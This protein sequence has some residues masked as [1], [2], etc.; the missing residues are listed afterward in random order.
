MKTAQETV[1]R[2][3]K[4]VQLDPVDSRAHLCLGWSHAF[5]QEHDQAGT[6]M[7]LARELNPYDPGTLMSAAGY[8]AFSG[9]IGKGLA[10]ARE[11]IA[12]SISPAV[13]HWTYYAMVLF[14]SGN[15]AAAIDA[16]DHTSDTVVTLQ[17]WRV[18]SL[19][20]LGRK[21]DAIEEGRRFTNR[22]RPRWLG[23]DAPTDVAIVRWL[24]H[25]HPIRWP[26]QS[27]LVCATVWRE[28]SP[29]EW[30]RA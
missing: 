26:A 23:Q 25:V 4:A 2:A 17:A 20:H 19:F 13:I 12:P 8:W 6:H 22:V 29:N 3:K 1:A 14:L 24:L 11:A 28:P 15:D 21:Q 18:A 30:H 10:L 7:E 5:A 9:D 16:I 27:G